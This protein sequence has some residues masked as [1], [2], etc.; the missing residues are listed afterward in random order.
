[1]T[2]A[3]MMT[4]TKILTMTTTTPSGKTAEIF[5]DGAAGWTARYEVV[6]DGVGGGAN[7]GPTEI[8]I[9]SHR[10]P[11]MVK[12]IAWGAKFVPLTDAQVQS[13]GGINAAPAPKKSMPA[14]RC[15]VCGGTVDY[16]EQYATRGYCGCQGE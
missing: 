10:A 4:A 2:T 14:P 12:V 5:C 3:T 9:G 16:S 7:A 8:N 15:R 6:I 1:M 13:L 11:K